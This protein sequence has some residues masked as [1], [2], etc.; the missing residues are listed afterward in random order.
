MK[1]DRYGRGGPGRKGF[2]RI[3]KDPM[4]EGFLP[5]MHRHASPCVAM[6]RLCIGFIGVCICEVKDLH[7][8]LAIAAIRRTQTP[9]AAIPL[10]LLVE[11][12]VIQEGFKIHLFLKESIQILQ[13]PFLIE[14]NRNTKIVCL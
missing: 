7:W 9:H 14:T 1:S 2:G 5:A 12:N 8:G 3:R 10:C 11:G 6:R 4:I 13:I